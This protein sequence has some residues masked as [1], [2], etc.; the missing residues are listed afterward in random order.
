MIVTNLVVILIAAPLLVRGYDSLAVFTTKPKDKEVFVGD[1]VVFTWD[2]DSKPDVVKAVSFGVVKDESGSDRHIALIK[3]LSTGLVYV[4][5][6]N[7][8]TKELSKRTTIIRSAGKRKYKARFNISNLAINDTGKFYCTLEL[9]NMNTLTEYVILSVVDLQINK[10][11]SSSYV[12]SW[13]GHKVKLLCSVRV[14]KGKENIK[15]TWMRQPNNETLSRGQHIDSRTESL[16]TVETNAANEYKTYTCIAQTDKTTKRHNIYIRRLYPPSKPE[17]LKQELIFDK[18]LENSYQ[19]VHWEKPKDD[20]GAKVIDYVIEYK[21]QGIDWNKATKEV[22]DKL[23]FSKFALKEGKKYDV[24]VYARNKVGQ[25]PSSNV[26]E[27][28]VGDFLPSV[29]ARSNRGGVT[30]ISLSSTLWISPAAVL[31]VVRSLTN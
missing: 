22:T 11:S 31:L 14:P 25:G 24:Q 8:I 17:N 12:E 13:D 7:Q 27:I 20:G 1:N 18:D 19:K 30:R 16:L 5:S 10:E 3:K 4:N 28:K 2:Y 21:P 9:N 23:E 29:E 15:F 6:K 26:V